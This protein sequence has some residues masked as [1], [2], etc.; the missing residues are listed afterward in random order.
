MTG[1]KSRSIS[2]FYRGDLL[3]SVFSPNEEAIEDLGVAWE[4]LA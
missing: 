4:I 1:E 3:V 2:V